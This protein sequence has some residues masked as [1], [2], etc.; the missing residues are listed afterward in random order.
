MLQEEED[1][2]GAAATGA[3]PVSS[4]P[5]VD[6]GSSLLSDHEQA[7]ALAADPGPAAA[8]GLLSGVLGCLQCRRCHTSLVRFVCQ[9]LAMI[10]HGG[11]GSCTVLISLQTH[12]CHMAT[13]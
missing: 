6:E 3:A 11:Q 7:E 4:T 1:L 2:V 10:L 9:S 12:S 8:N 13:C 5:A